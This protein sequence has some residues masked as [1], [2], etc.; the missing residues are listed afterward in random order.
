[1]EL[2]IKEEKDR[3]TRQNRKP[4]D[5]YNLCGVN[6]GDTREERE[7]A[8]ETTL[9]IIMTQNF[10]KLMSD[11]NPHTQDAERTIGRIN[12]EKASSRHITF[13]LQKINDK[14]KIFGESQR[15]GKLIK[16]KR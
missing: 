6:I 9:E 13:K 8:T 16:E 5:N 15:K 7:R 2:K 11:A 12:A 3:K 1:M 14:G 4:Q 10:P